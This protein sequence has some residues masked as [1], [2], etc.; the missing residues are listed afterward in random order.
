MKSSLS[1]FGVGYVGL[2]TAV[3]FASRRFRVACYDT[4]PEKAEAVKGSEAPFFEQGL[5]QLLKDCLKRGYLRVTTTPEEAV[6]ESD[7]TFIAVGTPSKEDGSINLSYV[8]SASRMIGQA[9]GKTKHWHLVVVKSTV[10]PG[11]TD[12]MVRPTIE[13]SS[14]LRCPEAFGL[15]MNPEFLREGNALYD[16]LKPD[17]IVIGEIDEKSGSE[18][19]S[20]YTRFHTK[21]PPLLRTTPVNA[22][23]IKY[24]SNAFLAT[25]VSFINMM[26][27]LCQTTPGADITVVAKGMGLDKRINPFFLRAGL[28][29]GGSCFPKDL[30]ALVRFAES[31]EVK[32]PIVEAALEINDFQPLKGVQLAEEKLGKLQGKRVALLGLSFKPGTSDMRGAPSIKIVEELLKR[33][34]NVVAYDPMAIGE[35]K[36]LLPDKLQISRSALECIQDTDCCIIVTEWNEFAKL[37]AHDFISKMRNPVVID[38]RRVL[39]QSGFSKKLTYDAIGLGSA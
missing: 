18:L 10:L 39:D 11:V 30:K 2:V 21:L 9:L 24:T 14:G 34:A 37:S 33:G 23:L 25:K 29:W 5:G 28:G 35:A 32:L 36:R 15:C 26:A 4:D 20:L 31:T 7:I 19:E 8:E 17:R 6:L 13:K 38:G 12:T 27:N 3:A 22:E 1:V 16:T